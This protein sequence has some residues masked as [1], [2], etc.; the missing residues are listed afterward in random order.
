MGK[1]QEIKGCE[2]DFTSFLQRQIQLL[3]DILGVL[4]DKRIEDD[5]PFYTIRETAQALKISEATVRRWVRDGK[6]E[7]VKLGDDCHTKQIRVP[8]DAVDRLLRISRGEVQ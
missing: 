2:N 3:E 6:L 8:R 4:K 1:C 5:Y 7:A